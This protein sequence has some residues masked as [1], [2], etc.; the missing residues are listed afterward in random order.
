MIESEQIEYQ[1]FGRVTIIV[2][3]QSRR[4][5][6]TQLMLATGGLTLLQLRLALADPKALAALANFVQKNQDQDPGNFQFIY[7]NPGLKAE[8]F[9]FLQ[10]VYHLYPEK[11][12][13]DLI[14]AASKHLSSDQDIYSNLLKSIHTIKPIL[15]DL[16]YALPA[17]AKQKDEIAKET[18]RLVGER[19]KFNGYL[20]IGTT[21]RYS[22]SL[23]K[24]LQ[25]DGDV[26]LLNFTEPTFDPSDIAERGQL[27]KLG[28]YI[29]LNDYEPIP[30][31]AA[32]DGAFE[33][34]TNYIGFH[35][36]PLPKLANYIESVRRVLAPGGLLILREHDVATE[37]VD[38]IAALAHDVFNV[39]LNTSW[40]RNHS[41]LRHFR[42][43][44]DWRDLLK[45]FGLESQ[46]QVIF[47]DGDPTKN[48]LLAFRKV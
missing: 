10:N 11:K 9:P 5:F 13:H 37:N 7:N 29:P 12:F 35:H 16:T 15:G 24:L 17:L 33:L 8:F 47:Q 21:G 48:G 42:S 20:E 3:M 43:L 6:L 26:A 4:K 45:T 40:D 31:T 34:V 1:F 41:E 14:A 2:L 25:L 38:R 22:K 46:G 18:A 23:E 32:K 39:G 30:V 27:F 44:Q 19:K 28:R 36:C